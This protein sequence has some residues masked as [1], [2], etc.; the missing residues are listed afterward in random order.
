MGFEHA[1]I[2][3]TTTRTNSL[4]LLFEKSHFMRGEPSH[5]QNKTRF[6]AKHLN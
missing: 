5:F 1:I 2:I 4:H 3:K 6:I